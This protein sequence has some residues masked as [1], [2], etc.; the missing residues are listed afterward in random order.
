[1]ENNTTKTDVESPVETE[2]VQNVD[3]S[4]DQALLTTKGFFKDSVFTQDQINEMSTEFLTFGDFFAL[5]VNVAKRNWFKVFFIPSLYI[6][7]TTLL[8][9]I[10]SALLIITL[11][12]L[13]Q[14]NG[15]IMALALS[16]ILFVVAV[17][18]VI[19]FSI[20]SLLVLKNTKH[21]FLSKEYN[22]KKY[23]QP[24][25]LSFVLLGLINYG[26]GILGVF[27]VI[28]FILPFVGSLFYTLL[29]GNV[30]LI[31]IFEN[32]GPIDSV[33]INV[34]LGLSKVGSLFWRIFLITVLNIV[35]AILL[36]IIGG[37][38][39]FGLGFVILPLLTN[40]TLGGLAVVL[41]M[42]VTAIAG[43]VVI[44]LAYNV[45][46]SALLLTN[47]ANLRLAPKGSK[48]ESHYLSYKNPFTQS[49]IVLIIVG[50][51]IL[52]SI[53]SGNGQSSLPAIDKNLID[54]LTN[55]RVSNIL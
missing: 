22:V 39:A 10:V 26:L 35:F 52:G 19:N 40:Y 1:M 8:T 54:S 55:W 18:V 23:I 25:F 21:H 12:I 7:V 43:F 27:P 48:K 16:V 5:S 45:V 24:L 50:L 6:S 9:V 28:G 42:I 34:E 41:L 15:A 3:I 2:V 47:Y 14:F 36:V 13:W 38:S 33:G 46:N 29:L 32:K 11:S 31:S 4:E 30:F 53:A 20:R 49:Q 51:F 37:I 44:T 17:V